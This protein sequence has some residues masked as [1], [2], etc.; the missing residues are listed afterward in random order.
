MAIK[1]GYPQN[2]T[3]NRREAK[4]RYQSFF[5]MH[6]WNG[7]MNKAKLLTALQMLVY[8]RSCLSYSAQHHGCQEPQR[9]G[10]RNGAIYFSIK[11][12]SQYV[13]IVFSDHPTVLHHSSTYSEERVGG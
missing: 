11:M 2:Y 13:R 1:R 12:T 7:G 3:P 5:R 9:R 6:F 4:G 8:G 10:S